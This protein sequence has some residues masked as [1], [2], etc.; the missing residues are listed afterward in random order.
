[1][2]VVRAKEYVADVP[3]I[4]PPCSECVATRL[5]TKGE[6]IWCSK[7]TARTSVH[8]HLHYESAPSF[9]VGSMLIRPEE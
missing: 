9:G 2:L 8:P 1:V 5:E 7:H 6:K 3:E 4:E